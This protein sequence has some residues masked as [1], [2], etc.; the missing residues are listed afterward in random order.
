MSH[1]TSALFLSGENCT[2]FFGF[3]ER[4]MKFHRGTTRVR[5]H[6]INAFTLES[7]DKDVGSLHGGTML[8]LDFGV[9][10]SNGLGIHDILVLE[11][12]LTCQTDLSF[13]R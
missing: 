5:E 7:F 13:S 10:L 9:R 4:L 3:G 8:A 12:L 11:E 2:D 6:H 1:K